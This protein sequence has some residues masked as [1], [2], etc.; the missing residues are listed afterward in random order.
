MRLRGAGN[1]CG[2][3]AHVST[4]LMRWIHPSPPPPGSARPWVG[5]KTMGPASVVP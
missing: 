4:L 2:I 1:R 3:E 5:P